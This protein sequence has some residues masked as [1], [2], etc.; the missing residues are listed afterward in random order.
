MTVISF[1]KYFAPHHLAWDSFVIC[2]SGL[3]EF[4]VEPLSLVNVDAHLDVGGTTEFLF[5]GLK[6]M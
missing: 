1:Q 3:D 5:F 2:L 6:W 4:P